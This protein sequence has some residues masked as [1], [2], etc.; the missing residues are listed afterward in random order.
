MSCEPP[1][2]SNSFLT[3]FVQIEVALVEQI[4][5]DPTLPPLIDEVKSIFRVNS[6]LRSEN[7][8]Y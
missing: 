5:A 8:C 4:L 6:F 1:T 7:F 3:L 2:C